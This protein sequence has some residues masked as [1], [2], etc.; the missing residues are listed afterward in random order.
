[1]G[2]RGAAR[3]IRPLVRQRP[4]DDEERGRLT[5]LGREPGLDVVRAI[6]LAR[7][8]HQPRQRADLALREAQRVAELAVQAQHVLVVGADARA[9]LGEGDPGAEALHG[10]AIGPIERLHGLGDEAHRAR[11]RPTMLHLLGRALALLDVEAADDEQHDVPRVRL[12]RAHDRLA[13]R[14]V[15]DALAVPQALLGGR[16]LATA[17]RGHHRVEALP[18]GV[19]VRQELGGDERA[20]LRAQRLQSAARHLAAGA[21][22]RVRGDHGQAALAAELD[23][24]AVAG[25][26]VPPGARRGIERG[27]VDAPLHVVVEHRL[28]VALEHLEGE[29]DPSGPAR[30]EF[31]QHRELERMRHLIV[32]RLAEVDDLLLGQVVHQVI[33][34]DRPR[35]LAVEEQHAVLEL[36]RQR[37]WRTRTRG[38]ADGSE[39]EGL[40]EP[41]EERTH[42][43]LV[44]REERG[45]RDGVGLRSAR[46]DAARED[47]ARR[48]PAPPP[49]GV[50][51][52]AGLHAPPP[53]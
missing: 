9:A 53:L 30:G 52:G 16:L 38:E 46:R 35:F 15:P 29:N 13:H 4:F 43:G 7:Q 50:P 47:S 5:E 42:R 2:P 28:L 21:D 1:V 18:V 31:L 10:L 45:P 40:S 27:L 3:E 20:L 51:S 25:A 11:A 26:V 48:R 33:P 6:A 41:G 37:A 17:V 23:Q 24:R 19:G 12:E 32:V 44:A 34:V 49:R 8:A 14:V 39:S 36:G 22:G